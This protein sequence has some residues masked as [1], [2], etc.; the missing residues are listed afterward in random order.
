MAELSEV[1]G[2]LMV[3]LVHARRMAD[4][5]TAAVAEYY[6]D[7]PLLEGMSL[8]RVRVPELTIS[9]P[10]TIDAHNA[11]SDAKIDSPTNILRAVS[12]QLSSSVK[13]EKIN[14]RKVVSFKNTFNSE[15]KSAL[16]KL[17]ELQRKNP[18]RVSKEAVVRAVDDALQSSLKSSDLNSDI[19]HDQ[20]MMLTKSMRHTVSS[21][22][23]K[24][25]SVPLSLK[26]SAITSAVKEKSTKES[27]VQLCI[28]LREEGLEWST[29]QGENGGIRS[30]LQPE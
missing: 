16:N 18:G 29:A 2:A 17:T 27:S 30:R 26:A 20:K 15:T 1:L 14:S 4:E 9:M 24:Q 7:H 6:K 21:I 28:T 22:A 11:A 13:S 3:S 8:P 23:L 12:S 19:S 25:S 5:E 10:I